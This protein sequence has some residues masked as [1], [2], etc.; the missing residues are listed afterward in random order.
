MDDTI[1]ISLELQGEI[2]TELSRLRHPNHVV[3]LMEK[4]EKAKYIATKILREYFIVSLPLINP[5]DFH[6]F[7]IY[8]TRACLPIAK[9][10]QVLP[11]KK[12]TVN[13]LIICVLQDR[14][15]DEEET[16]IVCL[17][18]QLAQSSQIKM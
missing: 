12:N 16:P 15:L 7:S 18:S 11:Q 2:I 13:I 8:R 1:K 17:Q 14:K 5:L 3:F 9:T 10:I 6:D 4:T